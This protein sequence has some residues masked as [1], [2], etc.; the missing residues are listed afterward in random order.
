LTELRNVD[1]IGLGDLMQRVSK[2]C[3][4]RQ[5]DA[6]LEHLSI[7]GKIDLVGRKIKV[8]SKHPLGDIV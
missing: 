1:T 3:N 7:I 6:C 8:L 5:L 2:W 4:K